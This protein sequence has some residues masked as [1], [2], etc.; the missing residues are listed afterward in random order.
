MIVRVWPALAAWGAGLLHIAV[1]AASPAP[2]MVVLLALGAGEL[3]WGMLALRSERMRLPGAVLGGAVAAIGLTLA[4][5]LSF[6]MAW[7]PFLSATALLLLIAVLAGV[8]LRTRDRASASAGR[9]RPRPGRTLAAFAAG[10]VLVAGLTT[11]A[12][13]ATNA[14]QHALVSHQH[15]GH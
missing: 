14:G 13:G 4:A 7:L 3:G 1:A 10:A 9:G 15:G 8:T 5:T 2:W 12:L 6:V 11:P